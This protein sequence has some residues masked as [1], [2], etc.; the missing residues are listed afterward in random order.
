MVPSSKVRYSTASTPAKRWDFSKSYHIL[1]EHSQVTKEQ[2][3]LWG[4]DCMLWG[5]NAS[6]TDGITYKHQN[7]DWIYT[8]ARNLCTAGLN[9]K[10][11]TTRKKVEGHQ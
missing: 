2:V 9:I 6:P 1:K 5:S 7:Q 3:L 4:S 10:I 8:L 11:E